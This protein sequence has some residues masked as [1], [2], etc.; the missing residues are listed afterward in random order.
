M[1]DDA[2]AH[3]K[4]EARLA[5]IDESTKALAGQTAIAPLL[6]AARALAGL[7]TDEIAT[8]S[9]LGAATIRRAEASRTK[10]TPANLDRLIRVYAE[11]GIV[12]VIDAR[13]RRGVMAEG[14][15]GAGSEAT[16]PSKHR[17]DRGEA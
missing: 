13:G 15:R 5:L 8:L 9:M 12:F 17:K 3:V 16:A 11:L 14:D 1:A 7:H 6:A 4:N 10:L 2:P